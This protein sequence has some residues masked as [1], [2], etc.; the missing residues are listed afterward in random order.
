MCNELNIDLIKKEDYFAIQI[1]NYQI[2]LSPAV[3]EDKAL[4]LFCNL[5]LTI[6]EIFENSSANF[7]HYI[8]K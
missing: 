6:K 5:G 2:N 4:I 3:T 1:N 8:E 7:Y